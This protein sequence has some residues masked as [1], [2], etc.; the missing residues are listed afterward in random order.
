MRGLLSI[1]SPL[2][3]SFNKLNNTG[4]RMLNYI[5]DMTLKLSK[6]AIL[7]CKRQDFTIFCATLKWASLRNVTKFINH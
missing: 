4:A 6:I 7:A 5:Y 2:R 1:L 3:N